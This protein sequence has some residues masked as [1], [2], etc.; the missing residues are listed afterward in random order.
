M[1]KLE[2]FLVPRSV[3]NAG[4]FDFRHF[5][6]DTV[7]DRAIKDREMLRAMAGFIE[8]WESSGSQFV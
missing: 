7:S 4:N 6:F 2:T 5:G 1:L 8:T 3:P